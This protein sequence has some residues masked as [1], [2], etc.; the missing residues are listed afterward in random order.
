VCHDA[1]RAQNAARRLTTIDAL[2]QFPGFYHLQNVLVRGEFAESGARTVLRSDTGDIRIQLADNVRTTGGPVEVRGQLIDVGR[3]QT[4]DPRAGENRDKDRWPRPGE[5]LYLQV[6]NVIEAQIAAT[7]TVRSLA[8]EPWRYAG[9][10][11]TVIG[12]FRGRNLFGDQPGAPGK[13][14][15]DFVLRGTEG[16]VWVTGQQPKGRGFD[17]DVNRRL[18][19]DRWLEVTGTVVHERGLVTIT[20]SKLG[21]TKP[22]SLVTAVEDK[23]PAPPPPPVTVVFSSPSDGETDVSPT[24]S[25][26]IQFSRG[27]NPNL[28]KAGFKATYVG[29]EAG[30]DGVV[31]GLPFQVTYDAANRAVEIKFSPPLTPFRTVTVET[32]DT[33]KGFDGGAVTRWMMSFSIGS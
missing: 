19:T 16:A 5:E 26:R 14:R 29:A 21:L 32:L 12:N 1:A 7:P 31:P 2:R 6:T 24:G 17:L 8:L 33:L 3:L 9:K 23:P 10:Q 27:L 18:D 30:A 22:L 20:A 13:G 25:V 15:Y 11:V 28:V 4:D